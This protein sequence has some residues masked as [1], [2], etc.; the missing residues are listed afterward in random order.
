[1][2]LGPCE[3]ATLKKMNQ[4]QAVG[5]TRAEL[6]TA[7]LDSEAE[8]ILVERGFHTA[9][10]YEAGL[11]TRTADGCRV[12]AVSDTNPK[13]PGQIKAVE[14]DIGCNEFDLVWRSITASGVFRLRRDRDEALD[15]KH[16]I[17]A[18]RECLM[19]DSSASYFLTLHEAVQEQSF[20]VLDPCGQRD[21]LATAECES[22]RSI[23][24]ATSRAT[25]LQI[26]P[27]SAGT[28]KPRK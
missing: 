2:V 23:G 6:A 16:T 24:G 21:E 1:L 8:F 28:E 7:L 10:G 17:V 3:S 26:G 25:G 22:I 20:A 9:G 4:S 14:K 13:D 5:I 27:L 18:G 15:R 19:S 12:L 11:W